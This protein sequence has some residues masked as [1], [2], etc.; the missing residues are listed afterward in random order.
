L[1]TGNKTHSNVIYICVGTSGIS[2]ASSLTRIKLGEGGRLR[3][4]RFLH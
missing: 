4:C 3:I 2:E 1:Q